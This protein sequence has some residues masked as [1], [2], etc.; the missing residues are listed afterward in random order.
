MN[1][2]TAMAILSDDSKKFFD[3]Q[4][5]RNTL[6]A[7]APWREYTQTLTEKAGERADFIFETLVKRF[8]SDPVDEIAA[9]PDNL[10]K[11]GAPDGTPANAIKSIHGLMEAAWPQRD[12]FRSKRVAQ[13][14]SEEKQAQR[15]LVVDTAE[16]EREEAAARSKRI[17]QAFETTF[18]DSTSQREVLRAHVQ[19]SIVDVSTELGRLIAMTNWYDDCCEG[20]S[21]A[22]GA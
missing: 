10:K 6:S 7:P 2:I 3:R 11:F 14:R 19:G 15:A 1:E 20:T 22:R 17:R 8:P 13:S 18:P 5:E 21:S 12:F 16:R 4:F 9:W